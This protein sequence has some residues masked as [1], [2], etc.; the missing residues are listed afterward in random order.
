MQVHYTYKITNN[1]TGKSYI[2]SRSCL[3][4]PLDDIGVKYF[5]SSTDQEFINEQKSNPENFEYS[6]FNIFDTREKAIGNEI[7]LH[8]LYDVSKNENFYNKAR[9]T[10][11]GFDQTGH[12]PWN[13]GRSWDEET[14]RKI[15]ETI[16]GSTVNLSKE[17]RLSKSQKMSQKIWINDGVDEILIDKSQMYK[18]PEFIKGRIPGKYGGGMK[19]KCNRNKKAEPRI[20]CEHCNLETNKGNYNRWHGKRCKL[21]DSFWEEW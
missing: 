15:S 5:S 7:F 14:K 1:R 21:N 19:G 10:S 18:Y 2:G 4:W 11:I 9:Q 20:I 17:T 13:K 16:A 12:I 6:I 3:G 8:E